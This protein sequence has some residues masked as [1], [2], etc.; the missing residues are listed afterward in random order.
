MTNQIKNFI[1]EG[2]KEF[3]EI[4]ER[5]IFL[6]NGKKGTLK[7]TIIYESLKKDRKQFAISL[8]KK[9]VEMMESEK[10]DDTPEEHFDLTQ[11]GFNQALDTISSKLLAL[12]DGK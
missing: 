12:T 10:K 2:D 6:L 3:E 7:N 5:Q 4:S 9:I 8:I 11:T 1:E